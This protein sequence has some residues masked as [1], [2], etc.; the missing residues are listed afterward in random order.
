MNLKLGLG[1]PYLS[2][3][4]YQNPQIILYVY[5]LTF[6]LKPLVILATSQLPSIVKENLPGKG[7]GGVR[8][9]ETPRFFAL[10]SRSK[11]QAEQAAAPDHGEMQLRAAVLLG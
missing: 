8:K 2:K 11:A 6:F 1:S 5:L 9:W 10:S 4:L 7:W 3:S